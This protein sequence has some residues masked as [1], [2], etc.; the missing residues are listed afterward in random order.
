MKNIVVS[1]HAESTGTK[2][3]HGRDLWLYQFDY[4]TLHNNLASSIF[5]ALKSKERDIESAIK[6]WDEMRCDSHVKANTYFFPANTPIDDY[7]L[8]ALASNYASMNGIYDFDNFR[9]KKI[10]SESY[11]DAEKFSEKIDSETESIFWLACTG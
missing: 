8:W 9:L 4:L 11:N 5:Q 6:L 7:K 3:T 10:I 1:C 2:F